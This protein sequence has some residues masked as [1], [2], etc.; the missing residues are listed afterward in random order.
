MSGFWK[1]AIGALVLTV[2]AVNAKDVARYIK[3]STM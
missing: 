3:I 1:L 2:I